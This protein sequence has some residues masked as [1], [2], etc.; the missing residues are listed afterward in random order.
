MLVS[1]ILGEG[2]KGSF[3]KG[4]CTDE[5]KKSGECD[6][7]ECIEPGDVEKCI[8]LIKENKV[9][10]KEFGCTIADLKQHVNSFD[11][12]EECAEIAWNDE[13]GTVDHS[14]EP[15]KHPSEYGN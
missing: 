3:A 4:R 8:N 11:E 9:K 12:F 5:Q 14:V 6:T 13:A 7:D 2:P 10:G 1:P 15:A